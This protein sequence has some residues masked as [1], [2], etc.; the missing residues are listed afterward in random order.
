MRLEEWQAMSPAEQSEYNRRLNEEV[1]ERQTLARDMQRNQEWATPRPGRL[2]L[3]EIRAAPDDELHA[4]LA[5]GFNDNGVFDHTTSAAINAELFRR[6]SRPHW[7][8]LPSFWILVAT[9]GITVLGLPQVQRLLPTPQP[10]AAAASAPAP[11]PS[12][13]TTAPGTASSR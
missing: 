7:S 8:V 1:S 2:S 4:L 11:A 10:H 13:A 6:A 9:A 12:A 5:A 3:R